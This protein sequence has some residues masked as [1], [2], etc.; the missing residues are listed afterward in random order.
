MLAHRTTAAVALALLAAAGCATYPQRDAVVEDARVAVYAVR[1]NPQVVTYAPAEIDQAVITLRDAD[2]LAARGG[3]LIEVRRLAQLAQQRAALAQETARARSVEAALA[4]QRSARDAQ[5]QADLS[6]Q[7]AEAAAAQAAAAQR[8]AED[9]QR[10][11]AAIQAQAQAVAPGSVA[12]VPG[13]VAVVPRTVV[14]EPALADLP[15]SAT[16]RGLVVTLND[17]MFDPSRSQLQPAGRYA[18]QKLAT[19]L[20]AHPERGVA[21][22]GYTDGS[23][24]PSVD[25]QLSEDR[26][27]AVRAA[28]IDLGID[29]RRVVVR[30]YGPDYPIASNSTVEGRRLNRRVEVVIADRGVVVVPRG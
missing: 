24:N 2:D 10:Q 5:V 26:A 8:Q 6:R 14:V 18:V 22:E 19:F 21:V 7:Q 1:S 11:A 12:V 3:S 28:L 29:P 17:G 13:T 30:G 20:A 9:A 4:V 16:S 23:G 25:R 15:A 27:R